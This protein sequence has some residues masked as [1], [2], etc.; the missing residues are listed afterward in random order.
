[1]SDFE[2]IIESLRVKRKHTCLHI[3]VVVVAAFFAEK[4][5]I[6]FDNIGRKAVI[7]FS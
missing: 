6:C 1:M 2:N 4:C 5:V 3:P 7:L